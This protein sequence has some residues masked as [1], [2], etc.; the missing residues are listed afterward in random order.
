MDEHNYN[1]SFLEDIGLLRWELHSKFS[2]DSCALP[3]TPAALKFH[4]LRANFIA[5]TWKR[6]ILSL[7]PTLPGLMG[8]GWN[9]DFVPIMTDELPAPEFSLELTICGCKKT[10]CANNQCSC[11]KHKLICTEACQCTT[12]ENEVLSFE[13]IGLEE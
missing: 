5:L 4:L 11:R 6:L 13:D 7:D 12:C 10:H 8:N 1:Y 2:N 9:K 3:P